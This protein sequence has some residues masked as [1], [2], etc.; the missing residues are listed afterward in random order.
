MFSCTASRATLLTGVSL[1]ALLVG[2]LTPAEARSVRQAGAPVTNATAQQMAAQQ[3]AAV[4]AQQSRSALIRATQS[5][6]AVQA[7]QTAAR[8]A[9]QARQTSLTSPV[10][11][12]NGLAVGGLEPDSR[13]ASTGVANPV[14]TWVG[15]RTPTQTF[16]ATRPSSM[17]N[18]PRRRRSSTGQA[19]TSARAPR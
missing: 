17:S 18:R 19:S 12:P 4:I 7:L 8:G 6:Q 3:Q 16:R 9:A 1:A 2:A 5:M 14:T 11:V 13:L 15:A 10:N